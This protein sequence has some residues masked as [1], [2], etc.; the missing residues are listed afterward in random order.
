[1][2]RTISVVVAATA[3]TL[4][5]QGCSSTRKSESYQPTHQAAAP[6]SAPA[7]VAEKT[8]PPAASTLPMNA[9]TVTEGATPAAQTPAPAPPAASVEPASHHAATRLP[10]T[11]S[12]RPLILLAGLSALVAAETMR[13]ASV[14]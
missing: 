8:A 2:I 7:H 9:A 1:M 11:A 12:D 5:A 10:K 3:L 13:R 14:G 6:T 4:A